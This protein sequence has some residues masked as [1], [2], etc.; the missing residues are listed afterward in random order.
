MC[1]DVEVQFQ[2]LDGG[3]GQFHT[4]ATLFLGK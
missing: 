3:E 1:G 4:L 2:A